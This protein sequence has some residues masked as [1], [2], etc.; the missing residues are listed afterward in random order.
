MR[1][2]F[3]LCLG[4]LAGGSACAVEPSARI[5]RQLYSAGLEARAAV[6]KI[7]RSLPTAGRGFGEGVAAVEAVTRRYDALEQ[8]PRAS[9][10][11]RL[12]AILGE[13]RAWDDASHAILGARLVEGDEEIAGDMLREKAFP[14]TIAAQNAYQRAL[15][16]ACEH[17]L[18]DRAAMPEILDGLQRT[19]GSAPASDAPC[20]R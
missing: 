3:W 20:P 5:D 19:L 13:A 6:E 16:F 12:S 2:A 1:R 14:A 9:D 7:R 18:E 10:G 8:D 17:H 15:A 11:Q 4:V